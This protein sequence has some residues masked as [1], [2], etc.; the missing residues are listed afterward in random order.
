MK[1][2]THTRMIVASWKDVENAAMQGT[3]TGVALNQREARK[4]GQS[5]Y[6]VIVV[7]SL[8]RAQTINRVFW[9]WIGLIGSMLLFVVSLRYLRIAV[10][11]RDYYERKGKK[12]KSP[13]LVDHIPKEAGESKRRRKKSTQKTATGGKETGTNDE[14]RPRRG[15]WKKRNTK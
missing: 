5:G 8:T 10:I 4:N 13:L 14:A 11:Y 7:S 6:H 9:A 15:F 12:L 2:A 1:F 3:L